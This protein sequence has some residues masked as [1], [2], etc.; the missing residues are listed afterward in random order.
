M[1][2]HR[3]SLKADCLLPMT[4]SCQPL[5]TLKGDN[6]C[7]AIPNYGRLPRFSALHTHTHTQHTNIKQVNRRPSTTQCGVEIK[8]AHCGLSRCKGS[9]HPKMG[10]GEQVSCE[11]QVSVGIRPASVWRHLTRRAEQHVPLVASNHLHQHSNCTN[12]CCCSS[13]VHDHQR[14]FAFIIGS[15]LYKTNTHYFTFPDPP[16][17]SLRRL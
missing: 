13:D 12:S 3:G 2:M 17:A 8:Q 16:Y 15:E 10:D 14:P 9:P 1:R 6:R 4:S 7:S 11:A 5:D